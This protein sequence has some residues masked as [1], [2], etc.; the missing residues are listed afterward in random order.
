MGHPYYYLVQARDEEKFFHGQAKVMILQSPV[1]RKHRLHI[2]LAFRT[3][4]WKTRPEQKTATVFCST[5]TNA[6]QD[7]QG[8]HFEFPACVAHF[9]AEMK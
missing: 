6:Q 1:A 8:A 5:F 7:A 2:F 4:T 9:R 3:E